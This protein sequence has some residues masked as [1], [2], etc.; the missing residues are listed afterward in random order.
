M[1]FEIGPRNQSRRREALNCEAELWSSFSNRSQIFTEGMTK[2]M[3]QDSQGFFLQCSLYS[4]IAI[5][6]V[7][8]KSSSR[9][10]FITREID[11]PIAAINRQ[12]TSKIE[13]G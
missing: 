1:R 6:D 5:V 4:Q 2:T 3:Q 9:D 8:V 11:L 10:D 12:S 7:S 13:E